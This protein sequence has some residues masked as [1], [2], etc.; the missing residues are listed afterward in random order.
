[1]CVYKIV[2]KLDLYSNYSFVNIFILILNIRAFAHAIKFYM[3]LPREKN[4]R[5]RTLEQK[6]VN[7]CP[8]MDG[9]KKS[10][11]EGGIQAEEVT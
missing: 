11:T 10:K 1:M 2:T 5:K 8:L 7:N 6:S 4:P 9:K 3:I